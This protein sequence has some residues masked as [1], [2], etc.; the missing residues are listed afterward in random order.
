[1]RFTDNIFDDV[2]GDI[3]VTRFVFTAVQQIFDIAVGPLYRGKSEPQRRQAV[4]GNAVD[5]AADDVE[6]LQFQ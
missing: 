1:M 3:V 6:D 4:F 5:A 2:I